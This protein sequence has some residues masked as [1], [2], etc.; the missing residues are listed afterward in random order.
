MSK[1]KPFKKDSFVFTVKADKTSCGALRIYK[2]RV[3][4]VAVSKI[5]GW[6]EIMVYKSPRRE[7]RDS[8]T[9]VDPK[10]LRQA[11]KEE[12]KENWK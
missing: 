11:T 9:D 1:K 7:S 6:G 2:D 5:D 4:K 3:L 8:A 12:V 10:N